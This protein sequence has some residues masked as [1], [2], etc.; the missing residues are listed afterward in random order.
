MHA[1]EFYKV[2]CV[3]GPS[4]SCNLEGFYFPSLCL[5]CSNKRVVIIFS[6]VHGLVNVYIVGK[7]EFNHLYREVGCKK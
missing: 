6:G 3:N 4:D 1:F 7:C 5:D 2:A